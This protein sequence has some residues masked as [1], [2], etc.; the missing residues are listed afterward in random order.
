[1]WWTPRTSPVS[2]FFDSRLSQAPWCALPVHAGWQPEPYS[3]GIWISGGRVSHRP[4]GCGFRGIAVAF[5]RGR[6][7]WAVA[8]TGRPCGKNLPCAR[9]ETAGRNGVAAT[10]RRRHCSRRAA[11]AFCGRPAFKSTAC[12]SAARPAGALS[13]KHSRLLDRIAVARGTEQASAAHD[14]RC[15]ASHLA[16]DSR[17]NRQSFFGG[18]ALRKLAQSHIRSESGTRKI[19]AIPLNFQI[20]LSF[21]SRNRASKT[22]R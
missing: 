7:E 18:I 12:L 6:M 2:R 17:G 4:I 13:K 11:C 14:G 8:C 1:M 5:R 3:G 21:L 10:R 16:F 19:N 20:V 9:R 15:R 22:V